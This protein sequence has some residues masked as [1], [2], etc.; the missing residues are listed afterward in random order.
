LDFGFQVL[1][2]KL[3]EKLSALNEEAGDYSLE[4]E[5]KLFSFAF[6]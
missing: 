3:F 5:V 2:L 6:S 4:K 1:P